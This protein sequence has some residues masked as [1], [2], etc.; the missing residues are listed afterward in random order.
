[1]Y[2]LEKDSWIFCWFWMCLGDKC[3]GEQQAH[4]Q[5]RWM[6]LVFRNRGVLKSAR[7]CHRGTGQC[8]SLVT[9]GAFRTANTDLRC[10]GIC[11]HHLQTCLGPE[12]GDGNLRR[13]VS[14]YL[15]RSLF[16]WTWRVTETFLKLP[17]LSLPFTQQIRSVVPTTAC[18][19][20]PHKDPQQPAAGHHAKTHQSSA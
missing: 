10:V 20:T 1:M 16:Y 3:S 18:R 4:V 13:N 5:M 9:H 8:P 12:D 2:F 6:L 19:S 11:F 7:G 15:P 14:N 17:T